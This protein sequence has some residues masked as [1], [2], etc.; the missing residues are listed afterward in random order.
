MEMCGQPHILI[1]LKKPSTLVKPKV[2]KHIKLLTSWNTRVQN[3]AT[4]MYNLF[5]PHAVKSGLDSKEQ[6][7]DYRASL[8]V[9]VR[10][11]GE[12]RVELSLS[13]YA[14]TFR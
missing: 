4:E 1:Y 5:S 11:E 13:S 8:H 12:E 2:T 6:A 14:F 7:Q 9:S 3:P 10:Y